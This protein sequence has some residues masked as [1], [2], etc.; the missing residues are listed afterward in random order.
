MKKTLTENKSLLLRND[1]ATKHEISTDKNDPSLFME[2]WVR[3][4]SYFDIQ[5]SV[6]KLLNITQSGGVKFNLQA[7]WR[8]AFSHWIEKTNP[9]LTVSELL[10]LNG[11][12][13]DQI[14]KILPKPNEIL[15]DIT[16]NFTNETE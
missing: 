15:E 12:V 3:D 5:Q 7:Y 1:K 2:V 10:N 16:G 4:I 9:E 6:E 8:Y 11:Y 14:S 13:G